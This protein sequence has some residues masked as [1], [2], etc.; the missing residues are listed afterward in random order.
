MSNKKAIFKNKGFTLIELLVVISIIGFIAA[1][2]VVSFNIV[3]MQSRDAVRSGNVSTLNRALA[4]YLN[5][6]GTYPAPA[7]G[8][9]SGECLSSAG[10]GSSL[11]SAETIVNIP[12]DPLWTAAPSTFNG[13]ATTDYAV[14]PSANFCYWYYATSNSYYISY[15]LE[16][17]S[18]AGDSGIHVMTSGGSITP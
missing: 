3:R 17:N 5:D 7:G 6:F 18:N 4:L 15:Y 8:Y 14:A 2:S 9:G 10:A 11:I 16:S 12:I 13:G 1:A